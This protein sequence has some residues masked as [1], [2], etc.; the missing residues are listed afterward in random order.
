MT[1]DLEQFALAF[2]ACQTP[3]Q[4]EQTIA[5]AR[6]DYDADIRSERE[7]CAKVASDYADAVSETRPADG[8]GKVAADLV[9]GACRNIAAVIRKGD[10]A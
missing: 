9:V 10:A 7:R 3:E 8:F 5:A 2:M 6:E 4:I 1:L